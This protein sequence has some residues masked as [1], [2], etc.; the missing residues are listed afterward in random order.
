[1]LH[2][3]EMRKI[4]R[5]RAALHLQRLSNG[6]EATQR[7]YLLALRVELTQRI[8][9]GLAYVHTLRF[10]KIREEIFEVKHAVDSTIDVVENL[11][12]E[13]NLNKYVHMHSEIDVVTNSLQMNGCT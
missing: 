3:D 7:K 11:K 13:N 1:M 6:N 2:S 8:R 5:E 10:F 4:E 12:I 9:K